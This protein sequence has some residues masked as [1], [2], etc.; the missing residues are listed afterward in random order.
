MTNYGTHSSRRTITVCDRCGDTGPYAET[1]ALVAV[2]NGDL[3]H[4][5]DVLAE[6]SG[7]ELNQLLDHTVDLARLVS[8]RAPG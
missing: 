6:S 7:Y 8:E 5:A 2:M 1:H 4:A 3:E